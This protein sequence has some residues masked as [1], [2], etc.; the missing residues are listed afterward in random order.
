VLAG[1]TV[2]LAPSPL[3][4][5]ALRRTGHDEAVTI[6]QSVPFIY[7][8]LA[9]GSLSEFTALRFAVSAGS[10]LDEPVTARWFE[11]TGAPIRNQYGASEFG[12]ITYNDLDVTGSVG[13]PV[14]G[15]EIRRAPA[16]ADEP[17]EILVAAGPTGGCAYATTEGISSPFVDGWL[18][19][20]DTGFIDDGT[21]RLHGRLRE[22]INVAGNK[23]D[24][25]EVEQSLARVNG[26]LE[27]RV[28]GR[29]APFVGEEVCAFV[30][31]DDRLDP[32]A[33]LS[34]VRS[35]LAGFKVP[36]ELIQLDELPRTQTGKVL[37]TRLREMLTA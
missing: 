9:E 12:V 13:R 28:L 10:P 19:T 17:A 2:V 18:A 16:P 8:L 6:F 34:H 31:G 29:P 32:D 11:T 37:M 24:P 4:P 27:C 20:G 33:V 3:T 1:G 7:R 15:R 5:Q 26:V 35:E 23:V 14:P 30:V 36:T 25:I 21:L 22:R